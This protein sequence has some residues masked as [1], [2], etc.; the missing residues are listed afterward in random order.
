MPAF[1]P[2]PLRLSFGMRHY[3]FGERLIADRLGK[4]DLPPGNVAETWEVS[5]HDDLP[6]TIRNGAYRGESLR[7][8]VERYPDEL[9]APGWLGRHFPLLVKFLDASHPLPI[10]LHPD[11]ASARERYGQANGKNE[12]WHILWAEPGAKV[13]VGVKPGTSREE[14]EAAC[15][16]GR[17]TELMFEYPVEAGDTVHVPGGVLHTFGP[18]T[19]ILEVMQTS[20][21]GASVSPNDV[22]GRPLAHDTWRANIRETLELLNWTDHPRPTPGDRVE[23]GSWRR[24]I[25]C[26]DPHFVLE[27]WAFSG[28]IHAQPGAGG[29]ATLTNLGASIE[30]AAAGGR[31]PLER[32]SSCL[33]PAA[34]GTVTLAAPTGESADVVVCRLPQPDRVIQAS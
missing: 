5:D 30:I 22:Y 23:R 34:L 8:L 9:V 15:L 10:H 25:G 29:C 11:D 24:T 4:A 7:S 33:L 14:L 31:W 13:F 12:A 1:D 19:L 2:Y 32:A 20:D 27:R 26:V 17:A 3:A 16:A 28:E 18:G 21:L 6:A